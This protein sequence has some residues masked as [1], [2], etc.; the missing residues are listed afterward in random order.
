MKEAL[1][2][3]WNRFSAWFKKLSTG[4]KVM[5][6]L[7]AVCV[8]TAQLGLALILVGCWWVANNTGKGGRKKKLQKA[9]IAAKAYFEPIIASKTLPVITVDVNLQKDEKCYYVEENVSLGEERSVR[10]TRGT[11]ASV[12]V[13]KGVWVHGYGS[14][15]ISTPTLRKVD[16]GTVFLTNKRLIFLG[17]FHNKNIKY[18]DILATNQYSDAISLSIASN[19][20][21]EYFFV[22]NS[23]LLKGMM[24]FAPYGDDLKKIK[25]I[26]MQFQTN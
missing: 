2:K 6:V 3:Y 12:R 4:G 9:E 26:D 21:N 1:T 22:K 13:V 24:F 11:G 8:V 17:R 5:F 15:S 20:K 23:L 10:V 19:G 7:I 25:D 14:N 18:D 16:N